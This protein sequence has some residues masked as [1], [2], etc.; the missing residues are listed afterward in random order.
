[1]IGTAV[2]DSRRLKLILM[3]FVVVAGVVAGGGLL[4]VLFSKY[5]WCGRSGSGWDLHVLMAAAA[6]QLV[7]YLFAQYSNSASRF[8][9]VTQAIG[10]I[11][12]VAQIAMMAHAYPGTF[13][14]L[15]RVLLASLA[16]GGAIVALH[17]PSK[18]RELGW[19]GL[20]PG[21]S[22]LILLA[23]L[24]AVTWLVAS[25]LIAQFFLYRPASPLTTL[26]LVLSLTIGGIIAVTGV[27]SFHARNNADYE[28]VNLAAFPPLFVLLLALLRAKYP[29]GAYDTF[30]YKGTWPYLIAD[31]RTAGMAVPDHVGLGSNFQEMFNALLRILAGDYN[32]SL[33]STLSI[34]ALFVLLPCAI[35]LS[36]MPVGLR[37]LFSASATAIIFSLTEPA[38]AQGTTYQEPFLVL[39]LTLALANAWIWPIF[40]A[41]A[42]A[43]KLTA[44]FAVPLIFVMK[45]VSPH[46]AI[47][48]LRSQLLPIIGA[49]ALI[50]I[51]VAPQI[52]RNLMYS[53]RLTGIT[54]T[55]AKVTDPA[56][57]TA[58]LGPGESLLGSQSPRG[59]IL[60]NLLLSSCNMLGLELF[61]DT[62]YHDNENLGFHIFPSSR[63]PLIGLLLALAV[64]AAGLLTRA[65]SPIAI[66][67]SVIYIACYVGSLSQ[68]TQGRYFVILGFACAILTLCV[69]PNWLAPFPHDIIPG[70]RA[71]ASWIFLFALVPIGDLLTGIY[72]NDGLECR[73]PL[74]ARYETLGL[75]HPVKDEERFVAGLAKKYRNVCPPPGLSPTIVADP[76]WERSPYLGIHVASAH[77]GH[78]MQRRFFDVDIGRE[79]NIPLAILAVVVKSG[80]ARAQYTRSQ[81]GEF[82]LCY[83]N[84]D[85]N[86]YCSKQLAP[87]GSSCAHSTYEGIKAGQP[88]K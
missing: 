35:N 62:K 87:L 46:E 48:R 40:A 11:L 70:R 83:E 51:F 32:P 82:A 45:F 1:M 61:C 31:W 41:G 27:Y 69:A 49:C 68:L 50:S 13:S 77:Y 33:I 53:G 57:P 7:L 26:P 36:S 43:A 71:A 42:I 81:D 28:K 58:I 78:D 65:R 30:L 38:L 80:A 2:F 3:V 56:S 79:Q 88:V 85:V 17:Q 22:Y 60:N 64:L 44:L 29:D 74:F 72:F 9:W 23:A 67:G 34:G 63:A 4:Q 21:F 55:L 8:Y 6:M 52:D 19:R 76:E 12:C 15:G 47:A 73:R 39:L 37:R 16:I 10:V 18:L 66:V 24:V 86:I 14:F 59:G 84:K 5:F 25:G 54:E 20:R 75:D